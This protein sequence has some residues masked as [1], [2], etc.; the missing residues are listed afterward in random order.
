M[1]SLIL[2]HSYLHYTIMQHKVLTTG[3]PAAPPPLQ[4]QM[5]LQQWAAGRASTVDSAALQAQLA[6]LEA[7]AARAVGQGGEQQ[8][9]ALRHLV[10]AAH[11]CPGD[12]TIRAEL[13]A[14]AARTD[15]KRSCGVLSGAPKVRGT[16]ATCGCMP[17]AFRPW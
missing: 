12:A 13:A 6:R 2:R 11:L 9:R 10:R 17:V 15:P 4:V 7:A 5:V 3:C 16:C 1:L 8:R 14:Q